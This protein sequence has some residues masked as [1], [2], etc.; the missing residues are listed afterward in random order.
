MAL[1]IQPSSSTSFGYQARKRLNVPLLNDGYYSYDNMGADTTSGMIRRKRK[2]DYKSPLLRLLCSV[3][4]GD[5]E[6]LIYIDERNKSVNYR[7][8]INWIHCILSLRSLTFWGLFALLFVAHTLLFF[9]DPTDER[10]PPLITGS[11]V[12]L[13]GWLAWFYTIYRT[14][15]YHLYRPAPTPLYIVV[16]LLLLYLNS[17][18][19][20]LCFFA[21]VA[22]FDNTAFIGMDSDKQSDIRIYWLAFN[23][24]A[25]TLAGLGTGSIFANPDSTTLLSFLPIWLNSVQGILY[26]GL[27]V[28]SFVA[29]IALAIKRQIKHL[30]VLESDLHHYLTPGE[31]KMLMEIRKTDKDGYVELPQQ[32]ERHSEKDSFLKLRDSKGYETLFRRGKKY[33]REFPPHGQY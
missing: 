25:E 30:V 1:R 31:I 23:L 5:D 15:Y 2:K 26:N 10:W 24:S 11:I 4:W 33:N 3:V 22:E 27:I 9:L 6:P 20:N 12:L 18:L 29:L 21:A 13:Y 8:I 17:L 32:Q 7:V 19:Q 28:G 16:D 14:V